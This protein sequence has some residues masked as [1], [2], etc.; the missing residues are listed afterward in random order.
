V[1]EFARFFQLPV[2]ELRKNDVDGKHDT[3]ETT[4]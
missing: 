2:A 4:R 3:Q 1:F